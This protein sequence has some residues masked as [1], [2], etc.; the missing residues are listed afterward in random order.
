MKLKFGAFALALVLC[1]GIL[2]GCSDSENKPSATE[3]EKYTGTG[4][5]IGN[6]TLDGTKDPSKPGLNWDVLYS[7]MTPEEIS[8]F[9]QDLA[10]L[11]IDKEDLDNLL[12][13]DPEAAATIGI[14][15]TAPEESETKTTVPETTSK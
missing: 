2:C 12:H 8:R 7:D 13:Y 9:E 14:A 11:N 4:G 1:F 5:T 3:S 15:T 10:D 6:I